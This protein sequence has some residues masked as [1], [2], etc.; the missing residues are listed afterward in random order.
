ME[1]FGCGS[2]AFPRF[3]TKEAFANPGDLTS[4]APCS[5]V[6][7]PLP[8]R[9]QNSMESQA[10]AILGGL[11]VPRGSQAPAKGPQKLAQNSADQKATEA[12]ARLLRCRRGNSAP[13]QYRPCLICVRGEGWRAEETAAPSPQLPPERLLNCVSAPLALRRG[14]W[15]PREPP[16]QSAPRFLRAPAN[17]GA[18]SWG[19]HETGSPSPPHALACVWA[20]LAAG[21]RLGRTCSPVVRPGLLWLGRPGLCVRVLL[22]ACGAAPGQGFPRRRAQPPGPASD[23][24]SAPA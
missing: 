19:V 3:Q 18:C 12:G 2:L 4:C 13:N 23:R 16:S 20:R 1:T 17:G 10:A 8:L 11:G 15:N 9:D 24:A 7:L 6:C 21:S 22:R 5:I 14:G